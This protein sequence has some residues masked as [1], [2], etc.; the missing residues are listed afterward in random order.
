MSSNAFDAAIRKAI[1]LNVRY[2]TSLGRLTVDYWRDLFAAVVDPTVVDR[3]KAAMSAGRFATADP[4]APAAAPPKQAASNRAVMV[5]E[6]EAG[7]VG[8]GVFMVENH[9][10]T[11]VDSTVTASAFKDSSGVTIQPT[12]TFD[13]PRVVLNPG[14][15]ILVR[16][17][18]TIGPELEP[19][20]RYTG[21]FVVPGLRG[22]TIPVVLRSR[23]KQ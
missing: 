6:A 1:D 8:L 7:S 16:V 5:I 20:A 14:E 2:Y 4:A 15:Q 22:T 17:S 13:P 11:E 21:E 3:T 9:L 18:T 19:G 10:S 12:F 23:R